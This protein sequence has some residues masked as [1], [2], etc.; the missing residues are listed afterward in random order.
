MK[1]ELKEELM[2]ENKKLSID[3]SSN[4][5]NMNRKKRKLIK[6]KGKLKRKKFGRKS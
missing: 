3:L 5:L 4:P 1:E 2:L 6:K